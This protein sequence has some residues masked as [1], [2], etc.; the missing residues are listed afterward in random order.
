MATSSAPRSQISAAPTGARHTVTLFAVLLAVVMYV[1][2]VTLSQAAPFIQQDLGLTKGQLGVAFAMFGWAYALFEIPGGWLGDRI[3]PRRVLMRIVLWWSF[4]TAATGLVFSQMSL[5]ITQTLFGAGEAGCFPNLTKVFSI[6]L[7]KRDRERAQSILWLATRWGG[8]LTPM[9]V[10]YLLRYVHLSWRVVFMIFGSVGIFWAV[11]F[12]R[13]FRDSPADHPAVNAA[14]L[15]MLP[16]AH[17]SAAVHSFPFK[18][19]ISN[20][21]V[22][23]LCLSYGCLAYGWWFYVTWLPTYLREARQTTLQMN[24]FELALLTGF[25]LLLGGV[26]CL[27]SGWIG[28]RLAV[29][30]NS[31]KLARRILAIFGFVGASGSIFFFTTVQDPVKAMFVLGFAGFFND[32]IMPSAWASAMDIGGRFAGT[33]SGAMNMVGGIAGATS[34]LFV[35]ILLG[36]TSNDWTMTL[37]I[38]A[39]IYLLG[40]VMWLFIDP[41]T[42]MTQP[43]MA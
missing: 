34:S 32:F 31:V 6:W 19:M 2:R 29:R 24:P 3:G 14:E 40:G 33:V 21:S 25:P 26:G 17:E 8:A 30:L 11:A 20:S 42:P 37:Y 10:M 23:L 13:W 27:I 5:V 28:P 35:P 12:Y 4:F 39:S 15:A 43:E 38:S 16:P 36:W 22:V 7:P 9:L 1:D 41:H 18:T